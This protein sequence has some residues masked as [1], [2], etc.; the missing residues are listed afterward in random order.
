MVGCTGLA[1]SWNRAKAD[2]L[3]GEAGKKFAASDFKGN[4][5]LLS[6][7]ARI[8]PR[9]P[10]VWWKLCEGYQLTEEFDLAIAACHRNVDLRGDAID[11]NSLGLAYMAKRDYPNAALAFEKSVKQSPDRIFYRNFVWS[12]ESAHQYEKAVPAVERWVELSAND[13]SELTSAL[14]SLGAI[15]LELGQ[16]DKAKEAFARVDE[17]DSKQ[18]IKTCSLKTDDKSDVSVD[19]SFSPVTR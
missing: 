6:E 2:D 4:V 19:C 15:F 13:P 10:R 16:A 3:I 5:Q 8:D 17:K 14:E 1:E 11:Y 18:H 12:L 9:N 7:A